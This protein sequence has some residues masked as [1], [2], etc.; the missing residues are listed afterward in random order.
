[1]GVVMAQSLLLEPTERAQWLKLVREAERE[2]GTSLP[3]D[4]ESYLVFMLM[5]HARQGSLEQTAMALEYLR[6]I[7]LAGTRRD[8]RLRDIGDQCLLLTGLFPKRA[9]RR[10]VRVSYYVDMGQSAYYHLSHSLQHASAELYQQLCEAFVSM[11]DVL[12]TIRGFNS[13]AL[14]PIPSLELWSDTGSRLAW[15]RIVD[16]RDALPL[17]EALIDCDIRQ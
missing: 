13:P 14:Q 7:N 10:N 12:Q 16:D 9:R 11:M 8:D 3:E 15:R 6:T 17:H 2:Y 4:I 5:R 1:M